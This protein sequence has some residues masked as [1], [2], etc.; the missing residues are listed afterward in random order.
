MNSN[1]YYLLILLVIV[2]IANANAYESSVEIGIGAG[3]QYIPDYRGSRETQS[4]AIP[5]PV[6]F[7]HG[8]FL[9]AD[10]EGVRGEFVSTNR[11]ELNISAD[12]ALNGDSDDNQL[13]LGMP[14]LD[15]AF[16]IGPS[17][18]INI[19]GQHL[20]E[21]LSLRLP[22]RIV[23]TVASDGIEPIGYTL[24]PKFTYHVPD[25]FEQWRLS[26]DIGILY[27]S[28]KFHDYYYSVQPQYVTPERPFFDADGGYSGIYSKIALSN[29]A[30]SWF[31]S[32]SLRYDYLSGTQ[33]EHSPLV[34]TLHY[35]TFS[36][37]IA[38]LPIKRH[39]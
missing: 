20:E 4:H 31:Y 2:W 33:F 38:W 19:T 12:L 28:N 15:T 7:Y 22:A 24:N 39:F 27:G 5:F 32:V 10:R 17:F 1:R 8:D 36:F 16:Q 21:G 29:H 26:S 34:E 3:G 30:D 18:N 13:R 25:F 35:W 11:Y 9:K 14:E 23:L 37:G 6:V